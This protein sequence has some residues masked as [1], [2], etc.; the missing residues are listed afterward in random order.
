MREGKFIDLTCVC[1]CVCIRIA[2]RVLFSCYA[3]PPAC[4]V[5]KIL[6]GKKE[7]KEKSARCLWNDSIFSSWHKSLPH[8]WRPYTCVWLWMCKIS[9]LHTAVISVEFTLR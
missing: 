5:F 2:L 1:V 3:T 8:G 6:K 7:R 9:I 4:C